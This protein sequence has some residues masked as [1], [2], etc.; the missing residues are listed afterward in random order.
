MQK[1]SHYRK[2]IARTPTEKFGQRQSVI[3]ANS[4]EDEAAIRETAVSKSAISLA[5][6]GGKSY[7]NT[8]YQEYQVKQKVY[9][10]LKFFLMILMIIGLTLLYFQWVEG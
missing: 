2:R 1:W 5:P 3:D 10:I 4:L 6:L 7:H 9:L 8:L